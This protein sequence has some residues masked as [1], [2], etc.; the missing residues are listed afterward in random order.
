MLLVVCFAVLLFI[1]VAGFGVN[2]VEHSKFWWLTFAGC[3]LFT[4]CDVLFVSVIAGFGCLGLS[5][6]CFVWVG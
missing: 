5:V 4:S 1:A 6:V 2:S 3:L